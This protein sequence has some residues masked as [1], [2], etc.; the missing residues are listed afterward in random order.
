M[1]EEQE[2]GGR[3]KVEM[4]KRKRKIGT[5]GDDAGSNGK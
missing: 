4:K 5:T 3:R 2:D 1:D